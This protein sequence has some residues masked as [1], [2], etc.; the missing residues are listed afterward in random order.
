M[1]M[2]FRMLFCSVAIALSVT[3]HVFG[4]TI[5]ERDGRSIAKIEGRALYCREA[6]WR[7]IEEGP[8]YVVEPTL[9]MALGEGKTSRSQLHLFAASPGDISHPYLQY[10]IGNTPRDSRRKIVFRSAQYTL[11]KGIFGLIP[12][13]EEVIR[14]KNGSGNFYTLISREVEA[15]PL[16]SRTTFL[17]CEQKRDIAIDVGPSDR[18]SHDDPICVDDCGDGFCAEVVCLGTGCS[19]AEDA[20]SCPRDCN[21]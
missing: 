3:T 18:Q 2:S 19:C 10:V 6:Y 9:A 14:L 5:E 13:S 4:L 7:G 1:S 12:K 11:R 20:L 16:D 21:R 17:L 8:L 15:V